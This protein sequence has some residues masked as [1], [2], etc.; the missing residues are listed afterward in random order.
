MGRITRTNFGLVRQVTVTN[1]QFLT[2]PTLAVEILAQPVGRRYRV[3]GADLSLDANA[4]VYTN[5]DS[6]GPVIWLTVGTNTDATVYLDFT[7]G[8][9]FQAF[10]GPSAFTSNADGFAHLA[11]PS[12]FADASAVFLKADNDNSGD[13]T[14]GD[15]ANTLTVTL[16]YVEVPVS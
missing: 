12:G 2:L 15:P 10:L 11:A 6:A 16:F 1:A 7:G 3:L 5:L 8:G 14:G 13:F 4:A 9:S